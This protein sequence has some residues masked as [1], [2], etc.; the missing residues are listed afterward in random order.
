MKDLFKK[1]IQWLVTAL[2]NET[3][4]ATFAN[5]VLFIADLLFNNIVEFVRK[6]VEDEQ[7]QNIEPLLNSGATEAEIKEAK[8]EAGARVD[9]ATSAEFNGSPTYVPGFLRRAVRDAWAYLYNHEAT[10]PRNE[11]AR[12]HK[13]FREHTAAETKEIV[14]KGLNTGWIF[15]K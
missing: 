9:I 15:G 6:L 8:H 1:F 4:Y 14:E 5:A 11:L 13:F 3:T 12:E 2:T 7:E 10:D